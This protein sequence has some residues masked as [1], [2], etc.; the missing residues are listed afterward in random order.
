MIAK[1]TSN[2]NNFVHS[3]NL[4]TFTHYCVNRQS[5]LKNGVFLSNHTNDSQCGFVHRIAF[6]CYINFHLPAQA[7]SLLY[8]VPKCT[9]CFSSRLHIGPISINGKCCLQIK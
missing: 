2:S 6:L 5:R 7:L 8:P 9:P 1:C 3:R 4:G